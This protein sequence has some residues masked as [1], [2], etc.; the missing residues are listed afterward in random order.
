MG[1]CGYWLFFG[2]YDLTVVLEDPDWY[3]Y[4]N[5]ETKFFQGKNKLCKPIANA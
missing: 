5:D 1:A 4:F 2:F 3:D